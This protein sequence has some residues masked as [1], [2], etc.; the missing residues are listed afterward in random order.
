M[1]EGSR[2]VIGTD[3]PVVITEL[4]DDGGARAVDMLK[5]LGY[6]AQRLLRSDWIFF[7]G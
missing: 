1:L 6:Q 7:P 3:K 2:A 4:S 5:C